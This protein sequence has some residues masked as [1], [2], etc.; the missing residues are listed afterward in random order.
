MGLVAAGPRFAERL[1]RKFLERAMKLGG[2]AIQV[3]CNGPNCLSLRPTDG[4]LFGEDDGTVM[5]PQVRVRSK[6]SEEEAWARFRYGICS[7][8]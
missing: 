1:E 4:K 2:I 5:E 8:L 6:T 3:G 7:Q